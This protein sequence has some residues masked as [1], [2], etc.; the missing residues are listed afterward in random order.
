LLF[1][2]CKSVLILRAHAVFRLGHTLHLQHIG[3]AFRTTFKR[4]K[5]HSIPSCSEIII[6]LFNLLIGLC[7]NSFRGKIIFFRL[8]RPKAKS[9]AKAHRLA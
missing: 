6:S 4:I 1:T 7:A 8:G 9:G 5:F 2:V 3:G